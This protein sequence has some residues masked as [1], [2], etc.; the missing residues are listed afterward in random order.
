M[1]T[2]RQIPQNTWPKRLLL[3]GLL[4]LALAACSANTANTLPDSTEKLA[5]QEHDLRAKL[6]DRPE[7]G[8]L[9]L[10]LARVLLR[11][12]KTDE[13]EK[14]AL[15]AT[16][17]EPYNAPVLEILGDI[18]IKQNKRFRALMAYSQAMQLDPNLLSA[19]VK[20]AITHQLLGETDKGIALL[21]KT[22]AREPKYFDGRYQ[23]ARLLFANNQL[24]DSARHVDAALNIRPDSVEARLLQVR[25]AKATGNYSQALLLVLHALRDSP[26]QPQLLRERLDIHYQRQEWE[27]ALE[28]LG[29]LEKLGPLETDDQLIR[30]EILRVQGRFTEARALTAKLLETQPDHPHVLLVLGQG[31]IEEGRAEK[32]LDVINTA[33][34]VEPTSVETLYWK[35][36]AHY[37]LDDVVQG[38]LALAAAEKLNPN[39]PRIRLMRMRRMLANRQLAQARL[40]IDEYR[41]QNPGDFNGILVKAEALTMAGAL[42]EAQALMDQLPR[43]GVALIFA[44][45]RLYYLRHE[46][47]SVLGETAPLMAQANPLWE[48]VYLRASALGRLGRSN[49][50]LA[51]AEPFLNKNV[52]QGAFHL[53]VGN[54]Y[55]LAGR[56]KDAEQVFN[57]GTAN[58]PRHLG[59][60]EAASRLAMEKGNWV[61]ARDWLEAGAERESRLQPL[62]YERLVRVYDR[63]NRKDKAKEMLAKYLS[64]NDPLVNEVRNPLDEPVLFRQTIPLSDFS[65]GAVGQ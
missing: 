59:L 29:R 26:D 55:L 4:L 14:T 16:E 46:Y 58:Y 50:G 21:L 36:V 40:L 32:A 1:P 48:V 25:I 65:Q 64:V 27:K 7:D 47:H 3:V 53:L 31:L 43:E 28:L 22:V 61:G 57:K 11:A 38:D 15:R 17:L 30:V 34:E 5:Q 54:L 10:E 52:G 13:A 63:L 9:L 23:L 56:E 44:R 51:L 41:V 45:A 2:L 33:F 12:K 49:E 42:E 19:Q 24:V 39:H 62:F 18:Y 20:M 35:A 6:V 8:K 37:R 60:L